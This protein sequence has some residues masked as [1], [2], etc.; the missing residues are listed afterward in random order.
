MN[1]LINNAELNIYDML[2][3][4]LIITIKVFLCIASYSS[5]I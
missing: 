1:N 2:K 4:K 3:G 5:D